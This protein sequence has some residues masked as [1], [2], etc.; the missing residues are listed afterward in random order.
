MHGRR[1]DPALP[2]HQQGGLDLRFTLFYTPAEFRQA[3]H[4]LADGKVDPR[5]LVTGTVGLDDAAAAFDALG[6]PERHAKIL[7]DPR[8]DA[9]R[10]AAVGGRWA[11]WDSNPQPKD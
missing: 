6:D 11:P 1:P 7:V 4:L 10:E 2:R 8:S 5:P 3:L 9:C